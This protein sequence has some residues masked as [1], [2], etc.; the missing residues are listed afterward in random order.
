MGPLGAIEAREVGKIFIVNSGGRRVLYD[1]IP[2]S[3][4]RR[5]AIF[6]S[7]Q[8]ATVGKAHENNLPTATPEL[9]HSCGNIKKALFNRL[10]HLLRELL[11]RNVTRRWWWSEKRQP[12]LLSHSR[13]FPPRS[14]AFF[15]HA[16]ATFAIQCSEVRRKSWRYQGIGTIGNGQTF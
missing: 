15:D 1:S 11:F 7:L 6:K 8:S 12:D 5:L 14:G 2:E 16:R 13:Q 4:T 3:R 9:L 10:S